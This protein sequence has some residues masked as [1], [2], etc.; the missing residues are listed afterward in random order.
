VE[1]LR[2]FVQSRDEPAFTTLVGRYSNLVWGVC[3]RVL[4]NPTAAEDALQAT[5]LRLARDADRIA[6]R[7]VLAGWLFRVARGCAIDLRRAILRQRR[8]EERLAALAERSRV[9]QPADLRVLLDDELSQLSS[10]ERAV[11]I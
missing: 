2:R 4:R 8:I 9:A 10:P 6:N 5:F 1:L 3:L 11:L 7:E